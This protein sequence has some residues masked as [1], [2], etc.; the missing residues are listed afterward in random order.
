VSAVQDHLYVVHTRNNSTDLYSV[1]RVEWL[2]PGDQCV[3]SW[4]NVPSPEAGST[5]RRPN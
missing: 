3:I 5:E 2:V 4:I 1:F